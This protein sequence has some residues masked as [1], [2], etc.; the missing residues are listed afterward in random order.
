[1]IT[2]TVEL[3][4]LSYLDKL[5]A[6]FTPAEFQRAVLPGM[7]RGLY[8][9]H[10]NLP[11]YPAPPTDSSY[12]RT[13]KLG[14]SITEEVSAEGTE[15]IGVIGTNIPYAP[16]VIGGDDEQAW[17]HQ[18]RWWQLPAVVEKDSLMITEEIGRSVEAFL[19]SL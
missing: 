3:T 2:T 12:V 16:Y 10:Q 18:G 5:A 8:L 7:Q 14:Q 4:N 6:A 9:V 19:A 13:G 11:P 15:V 1:M 17:M